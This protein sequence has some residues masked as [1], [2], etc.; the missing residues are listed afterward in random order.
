MVE[1]WRG[2][3]LESLH[4]G[5]AVVAH[6][7]GD[8]VASFGNP[9]LVTLPR[10]S[11]KMLQALPLIES[12]A[13]D[14][15]GLGPE[16][17]ALAAASHQGAPIH[18]APVTAWLDRLGLGEEALIC[19]PQ[20][21]RDAR[22]RTAMRA[23]GETVTRIHNNCSGK[24]TGFLSLAAHIGGGP[25]YVATSHP[26]QKAVLEAFEAMTGETSPGH[27]IDGCSAPNFA[28]TLTGLARAMARFGAVTPGVRGARS[29]GAF[30][31]RSGRTRRSSLG[32][33]APVRRLIEAMEDGVV[34]TGAEGRLRCD[35][36]EAR[37]RASRSRSATG[38]PAP[39]KL[40]WRGSSW[41]LE[42]LRPDHPTALAYTD[43]PVRNW[44]GL[45]TGR[46]R[47]GE[48]DFPTGSDQRRNPR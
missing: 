16:H 36:A 27:G 22:D 26:V 3:F 10:S 37:S 43:Q 11:V 30:S 6:A 24:H 44:D 38:R 14:R 35:P 5:H 41:R 13:A 40:P 17:I 4:T 25:D 34:K 1:V 15:F 7:S 20:A 47:L 18:T 33:V 29:G 12:G 46:M 31:M 28:A 48:A 8:V 21:P 19:G 9:D 23:A 42:R 32:K 39:P 2:P 45:E